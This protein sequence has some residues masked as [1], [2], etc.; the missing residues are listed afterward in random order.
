MI[1]RLRAT[2]STAILKIVGAIYALGVVFSLIFGV[3]EVARLSF[4]VLFLTIILVLVY[5]TKHPTKGQI[6]VMGAIGL[7]GLVAEIIGVS[8]GIIFG[9]YEYVTGLGPKLF[10]VPLLLAPMW[11]LVSWYGLAIYEATK[12]Q[13]GIYAVVVA[14]WAVVVYDIFLE[15][16]ATAS[17]LWIW[18]QGYV[19]LINYA[20]WFVLALAFVFLLVKSKVQQVN[21]SFVTSVAGIQILYFCVISIIFAVQY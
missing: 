13:F 6:I 20:T 4:V 5:T 14:A 18:T 8:T 10:N 15:P 17:N 12:K 7:A 9:E 2:P 3:Q 11:V 1:K 21:G 19:P 16:F